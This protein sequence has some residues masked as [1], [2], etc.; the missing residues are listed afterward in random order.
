[1][2]VSIIVPTYNKLSRLKL[3]ISSFENQT[4]PSDK[5]EVIVIDDG[6]SDGTGE[7]LKSVDT[8]FELKCCYQENAG[9]S[10]AR[11]KGIELAKNQL[12]IF[13]DDDLILHPTFIEEHVTS[14]IES[15]KV[16]HGKIFNLSYLKFFQD[17]TSGEFYSHL[18]IRSSTG[19]SLRSKC[20]SENDVKQYFSEKIECNKQITS[21][22]KAIKDIF[23]HNIECY[24]WLGFTGG[25]V[26]LPKTWVDQVRGFDNDFGGLWGCEDFEL[27]YRLYKQ[28]RPFGYSETAANYHIAHYREDYKI[29][30]EKTLD[31]FSSIHPSLNVTALK[32]FIL[33]DID[34]M[35]FI[36]Q[37]LDMTV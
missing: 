14:Q 29:Q 20:I 12:L 2:D 28:G 19:L 37:A 6:S 31:Y 30:I 18:S 9:R 24:K 8:P 23:E 27:G 1:M 32:A 16:L 10:A 17:P 5:F 13:T 4:Y 25:N 33:E 3:S 22:E 21:F 26:S 36:S 15:L 35:E 34:R 7:Y 11:N